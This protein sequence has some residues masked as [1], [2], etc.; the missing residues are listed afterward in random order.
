MPNKF[1]EEKTS[2]IFNYLLPAY[3]L[4]CIFYLLWRF[5]IASTWHTWYAWPLVLSEAY[6]AIISV[7]YLITARRIMHPI[8]VPP[9]QDRT[10]DVFIPTLNEPEHIIKMTVIGALNIC[11]VRNVYVL[12]DG[13]RENIKEMTQKIGAKY[14]ARPD[15]FHAKAGNMNFG[16]ENSDAEFIVC[17][18]CDHVPQKFFIVS[19]VGYF[20]VV[21]VGFVVTA[22]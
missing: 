9:L 10:V 20:T 18:D 14:L 8:W 2:L 7:L 15:N 17:L 22:L 13:K 6:S 5:E 11:G 16:L 21:I 4:V 3:I 12:D 1:N 19:S